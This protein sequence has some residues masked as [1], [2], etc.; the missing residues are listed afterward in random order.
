MKKI[1]LQS[2]L[3]MLLVIC[4]IVTSVSF[5]GGGKAEAAGSSFKHDINKTINT[6]DSPINETM[7]TLDPSDLPQTIAHLL[8]YANDIDEVDGEWDLVTWNGTQ[9]G[10]LSGQN[11]LNS[12]TVFTLDKGD[13]RESNNFEIE[14]T[15][16]LGSTNKWLL[17]AYWAQ[18]VIDNGPIVD[19][20]ITNLYPVASA[21]N[22]VTVGVDARAIEAGDY[23]LEANLIDENG[24]NKYIYTQKFLHAQAGDIFA[25][26]FDVTGLPAGVYTVNAVLYNYD[27]SETDIKD[28]I[29][30]VQHIVTKTIDTRLLLGFTPNGNSVYKKEHETSVSAD[31]QGHSLTQLEHQWTTSSTFPESGAWINFTNGDTLNID[32]KNGDYYLHVRATSS[33]GMGVTK[34]VTSNVFRLDNLAPELSLSSPS[35]A[36]PTNQDVVITAKATD[37]D[38][39]VKRLRIEG[40]DWEEADEIKFFIPENGTYT[41]EAEDKAGNITSETIGIKN[42]D[43]TAP[44][45][46]LV[47]AEIITLEIG[48]TYGEP[49]ATATDNVDGDL[50]NSIAITGNVDTSQLGTYTVQYNV[51]DKVGNQALEVTREVRVVAPKMISLALDENP[52]N[53]YAGSIVNIK[54]SETS[55]Q[56]PNDLPVGT[57]L[58]VKPVQNIS[59]NGYNLA[60][61]QYEFIFTFP[62]GKEDYTG[63]YS[64]TLGVDETKRNAA[65]YYYNENN[66]RWEHIGGEIAA[67][68][69]TATVNHFSI[70]GVLTKKS[71]GGGSGSVPSSDSQLESLSVS[72]NGELL[73]LTPKFAADI[74][75]YQLETDAAEIS[76]AL[77]PAHSKAK[78]YVDGKEITDSLQIKLDEGDNVVTI[79]VKAE[80]GSEKKYTL[81]IHHKKGDVTEPIMPFTDIA[82]HWAEA[83]IMQGA[84]DGIIKGY[85]DGTFKP[86]QYLTRAQTASLI[87]RGLGLE[88]D[89]PAPFSD[90]GG[91]AAET[92]AEIEAAYHYNI[93]QGYPDGTFKPA[94]K[95]TRAQI[96][97]MLYRAYNEQKGVD[98]IPKS[99]APYSDIKGLDEETVNAITMLYELGIATGSDGKYMPKDST[100]RAH[101]AKMF[102]NFFNELE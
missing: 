47:G 53:I 55:I 12:T 88:T 69:I 64:L 7:N 60:G 77:K 70:Y 27:N 16:G 46:T 8:I 91:Y 75:D 40:R 4:M 65:I 39:G 90:I 94:K 83:F 29:G 23:Y 54:D 1:Q 87:V 48:D 96:A 41:F 95:V 6:G 50:T 45:L 66:K 72:G 67:G 38:S 21:A 26:S 57:T 51:T 30:T 32:G 85:P 31:A 13:V 59:M 63:K 82:G 52:V 84:K 20:E 44:E 3:S 93:I 79:I 33:Q 5:I 98:Y 101:A 78:V 25:K 36:N 43:K 49:G 76:L 86:N 18:L 61:E 10:M 35:P 99:V 15:N 56:L 24:Y 92:Q 2:R 22:K 42:I 71:S 14:V 37:E 62:N 28:K 80:D 100:T 9:I 81:T 102:V 74:F 11:N 58:Q 73:E 34:N 17:H 68:K 89:E 19:A 97:L